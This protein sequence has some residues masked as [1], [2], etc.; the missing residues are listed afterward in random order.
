VL[1]ARQVK[2]GDFYHEKCPMP[3]LIEAFAG[4]CAEA[5]EHRTRIAFEPMAA[6]MV[7]TL[8]DSLAMV[9]GAGAKHCEIVLD[10]WHMVNLGISYD[11]VGRAPLQ[12]LFGVEVN[13]AIK[14][15]I[16]SL[17]PEAVEPRTFCGEGDFDLKGFIRCVEKTGYAGP[18][19]TEVF[20]RELLEMPL[21]ELTRRAFKTTMEQSLEFSD[22]QRGAGPGG[23]TFFRSAPSLSIFM[24]DS[25][26]RPSH[27][28]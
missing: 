18:W 2:V 23:R 28:C 7:R 26:D 25:L 11:E 22:T 24:F 4:L 12:C 15:R 17:P 3:R 5:A 14:E 19:G 10:L 20:A 6:A 27:T 16:G 9:A 21:E 13:D 1:Q 8:E